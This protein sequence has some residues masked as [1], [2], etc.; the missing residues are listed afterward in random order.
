MKTVRTYIRLWFSS[1]GARPSEIGGLLTSLG[2][3][4]SKGGY[5]YV[6]HWRKKP[7]IDDLLELARHVQ[8]TLKGTKV[9]YKLETF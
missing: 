7:N 6:Y 1:D 2:F 3:Q 4:P 8:L 9:Y 5:D